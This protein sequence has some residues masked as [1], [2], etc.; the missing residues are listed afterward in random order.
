MN[1]TRELSQILT[2]VLSVENSI[3]QRLLVV[4]RMEQE[5]EEVYVN[6]GE[7][8][9]SENPEFN[10]EFEYRTPTP[11]PPPPFWATMEHFNAECPKK[12]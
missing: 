3:L 4:R 5:E 12:T 10:P 7:K 1:L 8:S 6:R 9:K 11:E 2:R